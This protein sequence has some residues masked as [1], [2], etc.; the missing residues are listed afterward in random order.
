MLPGRI[1][2]FFLVQEDVAKPPKKGKL[3]LTFSAKPGEEP[4]C[5]VSDLTALAVA[6]VETLEEGWEFASPRVESPRPWKRIV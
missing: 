1:D 3:V 6:E 4:V 5:E 2:L